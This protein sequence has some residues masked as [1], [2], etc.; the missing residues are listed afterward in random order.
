MTCRCDQRG[1]KGLLHTDQISLDQLRRRWRAVLDVTTVGQA[2][3]A[4]KLR[5]KLSQ[6]LRIHKT[7]TAD[8]RLWKAIKASGAT[9]L[10][11]TLTELEKR[12]A[13][14]LTRARRPRT[15][16]RNSP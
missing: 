14:E 9:P 7:L 8:P 13:R 5:P 1:E 11:V 12:F 3:S 16:P 4:L 15:P 10:R 6:R 2:P